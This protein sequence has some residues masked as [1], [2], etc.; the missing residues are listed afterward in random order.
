M[1]VARGACAD[2]GL[3]GGGISLAATRTTGN[4]L[5]IA[6][7]V[8]VCL[9]LALTKP[10]DTLT[11]VRMKRRLLWI[12]T[13]ALLAPAVRDAE[14][15]VILEFED[16]A[17][18]GWFAPVVPDNPYREDH[19]TITPS[20]GTSVFDANGPIWMHGNSTDVFGF[21]RG[22]V[23]TLT[24]DAGTFDLEQLVIGALTSAD[25]EFYM[26]ITG[27]L[28]DGG[29]LTAVFGGFAKATLVH[30][31]WDNLTSVV[32][33]TTTNSGLDDIVVT[34][35]PEPMS[36]LLLGSGLS[37]LG[38]YLRTRVSLVSRKPS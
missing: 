12:L 2:S 24:S 4:Q 11:E 38:S 27:H 7:C 31:D 33:T 3:A 19:F 35:V 32:F 20:L 21:Y 36:L 28:A 6:G 23:I 30:L 15:A 14:A 37:V 10:R 9:C 22:N 5:V 26:T 16:F 8:E 17:P 13:I 18:P 34:S 1:T 29:L 25:N